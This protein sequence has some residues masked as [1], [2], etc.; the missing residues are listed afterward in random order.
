MINTEENNSNIREIQLNYREI[1]PPQK[2][3]KEKVKKEKIP[4]EKPEKPIMT[5]YKCKIQIYKKF[6]TYKIFQDCRYN[7]YKENYKN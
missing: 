2:V 1:T 4:K 7:L 6:G 3:R 5:C